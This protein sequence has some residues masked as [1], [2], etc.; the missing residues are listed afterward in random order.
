MFYAGTLMTENAFYPIFLFLALALV[1]LLERPRLLSVL[2]FLAALA[3]AYETRAQAVAGLAA[4]LAAPLVMTALG[5]RPRELFSH[6]LLYASVGGVSVLV[7]LTEVVRGRSIKSLLG[8]YAAATN[9]SYDVGSVARWLL[10]HVSE[11]QLYVG[12]VPVFALI[13]LCASGKTLSRA[14][15]AVLAATISLVTLLAVEVAAFASQPSVQRIE[16]RN[17]FYVA[18]LLF[19]CLVLWLE[20]GLP[21]PRIAT[22]VAAVSV[23]ALAAAVPYERF[24]DTSS[25]SDTFAVLGLWST[26]LWLHLPAPDVRWLVAG[27]AVV[28]VGVAALGPLRVRWAL[29]ALIF[30][31]YVGAVQPVDQQDTACV[32]RGGLPG[33]H[34]VGSRLD[35]GG[36]RLQ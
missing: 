27:V 36:G 25:T 5:R 31:L 34:P 12:I 9:S 13:L 30:A 20:R 32:D 16:E 11:L 6:T 1:A 22:A 10:W 26:A 35:H 23:V 18:P 29:P 15:R 7:V 28:L 8:A 21:R 14:D 4:A 33:D 3:L 24:F 17:L 2:L 19:T